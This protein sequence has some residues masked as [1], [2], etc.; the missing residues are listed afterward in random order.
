M[1]TGKRKLTISKVK[2]VIPGSAG[3]ISAI[4]EKCKCDWHTADKFIKEHE[5]LSELLRCETESVLDVGEMRLFDAVDS[6]E[7]WAVQFFLARKGKQRGYGDSVD[8]AVK[9]ESVVTFIQDV[10]E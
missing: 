8:H 9:T 5:E 3:I 1:N 7:P 10:K 4:A 6:G 2:K